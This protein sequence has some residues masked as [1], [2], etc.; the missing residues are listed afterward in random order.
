MF[1]IMDMAIWPINKLINNALQLDPESLARITPLAG[2]VLALEFSGIEQ[3]LYVYLQVDRIR[4]SFNFRGEANTTLTGTPFAFFRYLLE[5]PANTINSDIKI[6]GDPHFAQEIQLILQG[7]SID[8][9]EQLSKF[10]GD[11]AAYQMGKVG[12]GLKQW[13]QESRAAL[14]KNTT[15]YLQEETSQ[16]PTRVEVDHFLKKV[17]ELRDDV[18]R[19]STKIKKL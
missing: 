13:L 4:L 10:I 8:W 15:Q 12:K 2:R 11:S 9:E 3:T 16:L 18:E 14:R 7:L 6:N 5:K 1:K 17:D 19:L